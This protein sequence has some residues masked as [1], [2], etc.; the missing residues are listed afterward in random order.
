MIFQEP[1]TALNPL[2]P[3]GNQIAEVLQLHEG[4]GKAQAHG[5]AIELLARTGTPEPERRVDAFPHQLSGG[6]G[7]AR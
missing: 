2:Y 7:S 3:V 4:L 6:S 1:M 5:R